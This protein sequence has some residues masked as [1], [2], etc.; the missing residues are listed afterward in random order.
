MHFVEKTS[1]VSCEG[2]HKSSTGLRANKLSSKFDKV[3]GAMC[4]GKSVQ[5]SF[6]KVGTGH[7]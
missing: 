5:S 6:Y 4:Y 2:S 1:D 3:E 7:E